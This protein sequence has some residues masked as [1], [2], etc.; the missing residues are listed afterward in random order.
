MNEPIC[1]WPWFYQHRQDYTQADIEALTMT[2][3]SDNGA[4]VT[5]PNRR[6]SKG[7]VKNYLKSKREEE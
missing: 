1:G 7:I 6:E 5:I 3:S 4:R 2:V